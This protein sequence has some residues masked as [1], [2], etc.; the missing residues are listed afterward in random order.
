MKAISIREP[1][2]TLITHYGKRCEN[3]TWPTDYRGPILIHASHTMYIAV[4]RRTEPYQDAWEGMRELLPDPVASYPVAYCDL[5]TMPGRAVAVAD[6]VG[7]DEEMKTWWD[8]SGQW[9]FRLEN[10]RSIKP[11]YLKGSLGIFDVPENDIVYAERKD[12]LRIHLR[13]SECQQGPCK[14]VVQDQ[15]EIPIQI[16]RRRLRLKPYFRITENNQ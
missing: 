2:A 14:T 1:W 8:I 16:C 13:C 4:G 10:V 7:C 9:H 15:S 11:F 5:H 12:L 3:R 6:L